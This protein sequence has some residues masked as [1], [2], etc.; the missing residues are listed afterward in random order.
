ME[1]LQLMDADLVTLNMDV[2]EP[3]F[4][5]RDQIA[6]APTPAVIQAMAIFA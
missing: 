2:N 5:P 6:N 3:W 4:A 1:V